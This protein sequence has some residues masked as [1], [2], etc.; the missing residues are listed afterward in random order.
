MANRGS[1]TEKVK[2]A[3]ACSSAE[4]LPPCR[5]DDLAADPEP[6]TRIRRVWFFNA[7]PPAKARSKRRRHASLV[8]GLDPDPVV[9]DLE[10]HVHHCAVQTPPR[11]APSPV[12][13]A[14]PRVRLSSTPVEAT[15]VPIPPHRALHLQMDMA[16][17]RSRVA[18]AAAGGC[19]EQAPPGQ[20]SSRSG[21]RRPQMI[22]KTSSSSAISFS[23][24]AAIGA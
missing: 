5:L 4:M 17:A 9:A 19:P 10:P 22:A 11:W 13:T 20:Q 8:G 24:A 7:V 6:E 2:P 16:A 18:V 3:P 15:A 14:L 12:L 1:S 23:G 21:S